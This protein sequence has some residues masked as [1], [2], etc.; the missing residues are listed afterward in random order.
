M[1]GFLGLALTQYAATFQ[2]KVARAELVARLYAFM[3]G[4]MLI[5]LVCLLFDIALSGRNPTWPFFVVGATFGI[6]SLWGRIGGRLN[7]NWANELRRFEADLSDEQASAARTGHPL[8]WITNGVVFVAAT[9]GFYWA[10]GP[11]WAVDVEP[12]ASPF[13]LPAVASDVAYW[14]Y[15]GDT[16]F[17]FSVPERAFVSWADAQIRQRLDDFEGMQS[18]TAPRSILTY[19]AWL[20]DCAPPHEA[21]IVDGYYHGWQQAGKT[22][23]Y[24]YDRRTERA[25]YASTSPRGGF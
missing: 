5:A 9:A 16:V 3:G 18:I 4:F 24:A 6:L 14:M 15:A 23:Q 1:P 22:I 17:E 13:V 10:L 7:R 2:A 11:R 12:D 19:R 8:V 20:P 25:Y 21:T